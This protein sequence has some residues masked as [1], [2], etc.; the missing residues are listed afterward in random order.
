[1]VMSDGATGN[2][3]DPCPPGPAE[4]VDAWF[5]GTAAARIEA[6]VDSGSFSELRPRA[7]HRAVDFGMQDRDLPGDGVITGTARVDGRLVCVFAQDRSVLGGSVGEVHAAKITSLMELASRARC[8]V[9]ALLDSAGARL[10]EGIAAVDGYG[11]IMRHNARMSGR[12]PQ[13]SVIFGACAGGASYSSGLMDLVVMESTAAMFLT[14]PRAVR[15]VTAEDVSVADLG[16]ATVHGRV[17]GVA[18]LVVTTERGALSTARALLSYLP[19]SCWHSPPVAPPAVPRH[20]PTVPAN[21]REPYDVRGVVEGVVDATSFLEL[22]T[23][24]ARNVV[25]GLARLEGRPIGVVASQPMALAGA[26]TID[27]AEKA[28]RFVRFCDAFGIPL[29]TLVDTP[30]FVP[31]T[32]QEHA[33]IIRRGAK[34]PYAYAEATVP[35]V[36]V[37]LRKAFGGGYLA[38][39]CRALG[40]DMIFALPGAT[41]AALGAEGAVDVVC[42][43]EVAADPT[44]RPALLDRYRREVMPLRVAE[45]RMLVDAV[46][47]PSDLRAVVAAAF[48]VLGEAVQ[49]GFRHDNMPQ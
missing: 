43:R 17:S 21:H 35:R 32:Q 9:V 2:G 34:L 11:Q 24:F 23:R 27:A 49:P 12:V 18:H 30:G 47:D 10:Q 36:T 41:I 19:S 4:P 44:R 48:E 5:L 22:Q 15:A 46:V 25:V 39:G 14:G 26:L 7:A 8:P 28:A 1:M 29:L 6:L 40:A 33:G 37:I 42:R 20:T 16:G 45:E 13:I 3:T 31:G 38:M